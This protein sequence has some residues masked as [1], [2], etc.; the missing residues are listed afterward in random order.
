MYIHRFLNIPFLHL[1]C[2][3]ILQALSTNR[4]AFSGVTRQLDLAEENKE[5]FCSYEKLFNIQIIYHDATLA[6]NGAYMMF[7]N[8]TGS[9][10]GWRL[11]RAKMNPGIWKVCSQIDAVALL[12]L[13]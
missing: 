2:A 1:Q 6:F 5:A 13:P 10:I 8:S 11:P 12:L 9:H 4:Q 3:N 7:T